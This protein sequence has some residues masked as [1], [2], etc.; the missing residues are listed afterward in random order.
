MDIEDLVLSERHYTMYELNNR[1]IVSDA[2][3]DNIKRYKLVMYDKDNNTERLIAEVKNK[4]NIFKIMNIELEGLP[5]T[6][7]NYIVTEQEN[8]TRYKNGIYEFR[9]YHK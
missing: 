1:M 3:K 5:K 9:L 6:T 4:N 8:Y 2:K 7:S